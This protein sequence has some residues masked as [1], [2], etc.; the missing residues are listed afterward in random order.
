MRMSQTKH[1]KAFTL[2]ELLVVIAIIAVLVGLLLPAVQQAREAARR[3]QCKNNLK[4][5][6]L[7]LHNYLDAHTVFPPSFCIGF[8]DGGR[9]SPIARILPYLDQA[10]AYNLA[11]LNINYSVGV[12]ATS[13][14]CEIAVPINRCPS[15]VNRAVRT[16]TPNHSP[17]NYA[18]NGGSW[19]L[20]THAPVLTSGGT[21][22]DGA[23]APNS[24]FSSA[25]FRDG[26]SNT[27][28]FSE[29]KTY[30]PNV[31]NGLEGT[32]LIPASISGFTAGK[33]SLNGH[34]EW[35]DGK[36]HEN[37][38]TAAFGPNAQTVVSGIGVPGASPYVGD[39]ISCREG[40]AA[41]VGQP[42]Y[43]AVSA[44]SY[45][46][47]MVNVL[48]MDGSCRSISDNVNLQTWRS[49]STRAGSEVVGEF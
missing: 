20:F 41:C 42:I 19:K 44:R 12:N 6:G 23:F 46:T 7:A 48:L 4:Q 10:N 33:F 11:D 9:W 3:S 45:H 5:I 38:F 26:M 14:V 24:R 25:D 47:G 35:V 39:F 29:I 1:Q 13:G 37:G 8:G 34:T 31:G 32:D 36:V 27:L 21:P 18:F 22:G 43:A 28:C 16:G 15:E 17:P 49:L 2:I 30:T 40:G